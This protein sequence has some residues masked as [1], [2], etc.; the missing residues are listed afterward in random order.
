MSFAWYGPVGS[1]PPGRLHFSGNF[2]A[3]TSGQPHDG[4]NGSFRPIADISQSANILR[5]S[6]VTNRP[7]LACSADVTSMLRHGV[8]DTEPQQIV[9]RASQVFNDVPYSIGKSR[10]LSKAWSKP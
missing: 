8:Q 3:V 2:R 6:I 1:S 10:L 7:E 9:G 4:L 5:T